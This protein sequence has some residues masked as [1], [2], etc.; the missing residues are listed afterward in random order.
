MTWHKPKDVNYYNRLALINKVKKVVENKMN[1]SDPVAF[2]P[3]IPYSYNGGKVNILSIERHKYMSN[4]KREFTNIRVLL[5]DG[6][7]VKLQALRSKHLIEIYRI[8]AERFGS[9]K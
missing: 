3:P 8:L 6:T 9:L 1:F 5:E 2:E 7:Y 4:F